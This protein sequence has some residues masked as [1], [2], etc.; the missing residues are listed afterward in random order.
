MSDYFP[1][2]HCGADVPMQAKSCPAC[3]SDKETGWSEEAKYLHLLP[4]LGAV[5]GDAKL[6]FIWKKEWIA[7]IAG[8]VLVSFLAMQT[9]MTGLYVLLAGGLLGAAGYFLYRTF[10]NRK[11]S[12]ERQLYR[13]L[14][15]RAGGD[16]NQAER[17]IAPNNCKMRFITG[18]VIG[19]RTGGYHAGNFF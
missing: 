11:R 12:V 9:G 16:R 17:L 19:T 5:E 4:D 18:I 8:I 2:P 3:G 15:R 6:S 1:C 10:S 14:L 13:Q 7:A